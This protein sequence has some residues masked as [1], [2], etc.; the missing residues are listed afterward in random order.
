LSQQPAASNWIPPFPIA[1]LP[2]QV[3]AFEAGLPS[4]RVVRLK[5]ASHFVFN[6][7]QREVLEQMNAFLA[8]LH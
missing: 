7:N 8:K 5:G 4:A 6:S 1:E 2:N 3:D